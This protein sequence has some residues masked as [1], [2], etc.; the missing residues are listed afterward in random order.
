MIISKY[1]VGKDKTKRTKSQTK[2]PFFRHQL[3]RST[4]GILVFYFFKNYAL[5][6]SPLKASYQAN[7]SFL[8]TL[9]ITQLF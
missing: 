1:C 7:N 5:N 2:P 8:L 3:F 6:F 9:L 4:Y